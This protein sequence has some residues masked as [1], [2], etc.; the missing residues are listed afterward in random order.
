MSVVDGDKDLFFSCESILKKGAYV[1]AKQR[2]FFERSY[3]SVN[4]VR[5]GKG[6][7]ELQLQPTDKFCISIS[8]LASYGEYGTRGKIPGMYIYVFDQHG[9]RAKYQIRGNGN[10]KV[11]WSPN[12][13]KTLLLWERKANAVLPQF[14]EPQIEL[15]K[16]GN[17]VGEI[18]QRMLISGVV[19]KASSYYTDR[20]AGHFD[21]GLRHRTQIITDTG[22]S[23]VYFGALSGVTEGDVVT[24]AAR[25]KEHNIY[26]GAHQTVVSHPTKI[27]VKEAVHHEHSC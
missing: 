18:G 25:V 24:F 6:I 9:V 20:L 19:K 23:V 15:P 4:T 22:A 2:A 14:E 3:G 17:F 16:S 27:V 11:G 21:T 5:D 10:L 26:Q 13:E 7:Y 12:P 8:T 1:S